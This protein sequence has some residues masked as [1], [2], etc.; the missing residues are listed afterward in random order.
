MPELSIIFCQRDEEELIRFILS[1]GA[2]LVPETDYNEPYYKPICDINAYL[3]YRN[4]GERMFFVIS[5]L[6]K[7]CPLE[8]RNTKN[9]LG[10]EIFYI[11]PRNGG[12]T[13]DFFNTGAYIENGNMFIATGPIGFYTTYWNTTLQ[14]N[15]K[16]P[17][18]M[19][20]FYKAIVSHIKKNSVKEKHGNRI[21]WIGKNA[22]QLLNAGAKLNI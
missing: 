16:P 6:Y 22:K 17:E 11:I 19:K 2:W 13:I 18:A 4:N 21:Y 20:E 15:E 1:Q 9:P 3:G 5:D 12:P 8:M 7:I 14:K 10:K